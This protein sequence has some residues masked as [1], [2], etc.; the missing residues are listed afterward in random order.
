[1]NNNIG[2]KKETLFMSSQWYCSLTGFPLWLCL[3]P[4]EKKLSEERIEDQK[5]VD[6]QVLPALSKVPH[7]TKYLKSLFTLRKGQFPHALVF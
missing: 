6:E 1:M 5:I 4:Q 7:L 3:L 2:A